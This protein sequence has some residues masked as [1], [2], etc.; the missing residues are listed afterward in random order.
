MANRPLGASD[1]CTHDN[2]ERLSVC[3][4]AAPVPETDYCSKCRDGAG[5]EYVCECGEVFETDPADL[6]D[7]QPPEAPEVFRADD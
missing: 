2:A 7:P 1:P 4:G 3:C 5:F 6:P